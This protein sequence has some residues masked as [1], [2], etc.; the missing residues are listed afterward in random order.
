MQLFHLNTFNEKEKLFSFSSQIQL[1]ILLSSCKFALSLGPKR[2]KENFFLDRNFF[3]ISHAYLL[4]K[5]RASTCQSKTIKFVLM[6]PQNG[7]FFITQTSPA[8]FLYPNRVMLGE[9]KVKLRQGR[10]I[11]AYNRDVF[12]MKR[13]EI[14]FP[15]DFGGFYDFFGDFSEF[16][17]TF[18]IFWRVF[19]IFGDFQ[20]FRRPLRGSKTFQTSLSPTRCHFSSQSFSLSSSNQSNSKFLSNPGNYFFALHL[21][22][23][24][25]FPPQ[26]RLI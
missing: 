1:K 11:G 6:S 5:H 3:R 18:R 10:L 21:R 19:R 9:R 8:P 12:K 17:N 24:S 4:L 16:L 2:I 25:K 26:K 7:L 14:Y 15:R 20:N 13:I 22:T 23:F